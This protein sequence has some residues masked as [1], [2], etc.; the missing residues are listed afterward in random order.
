MNYKHCVMNKVTNKTSTAGNIAAH[1]SVSVYNNYLTLKRRSFPTISPSFRHPLLSD[2]SNTS[3]SF[4]TSGSFNK[5]ILVDRSKES[6]MTAID[7]LLAR[8][9]CVTSQQVT[10]FFKVHFLEE[11]TEVTR[12]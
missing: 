11:A 7:V 4:L 3:H 1:K 6:H 8:L 12:R 5:L 10:L 9:L 2:L